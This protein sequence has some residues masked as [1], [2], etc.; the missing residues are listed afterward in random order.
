MAIVDPISTGANLARY[1]A[2]R[3]YSLVRVWSDACPL[4]VRGL[5]KPGLEVEWLDTVEFAGDIQQTQAALR[6]LGVHEHILVGSEPG[7]NLHA[8]LSAAFGL[9]HGSCD[10]DKLEARRNKHIQSECIR[11][12]GLNAVQQSLATTLADV[13][14]RC[15][16][17]TRTS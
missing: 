17:R 7:V 12:A 13:E 4:E 2:D 16:A 5:V 15:G 1:L 6:E 9:V 10:S 8:D 14:D 3:G 11:A